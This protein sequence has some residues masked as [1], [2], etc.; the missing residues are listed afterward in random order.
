MINTG[1]METDML[2]AGMLPRVYFAIIAFVIGTVFGSFINCM[3]WRIVHKESVIHGR[4][5][6]AVC[7]HELSAAD[8]VPVFS[9]IFLKG[10]CRYCGEKISPRYMAAELVAGTA[11]LA[12]FLKWGLGIDT[13]RWMAMSAVLLGLSLVD[14]D[15]Y[16]IPD[17]FILAA[18]A[19]WI[20]TMPFSHEWDVHEGAAVYFPAEPGFIAGISSGILRNIVRAVAHGGIGA[21]VISGGMLIVSLIFDR[22]TGKESLGGGDIKLFFSAGLYLGTMNGLLCVIVSCVLGLII[23]AV[24]RKKRIPFGPEISASIFLCA[25]FGQNAVNWYMNLIM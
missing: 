8:L 7:G 10:K 21:V 22:V 20:V 13:A 19:V 24:R 1:S 5:H 2:L 11:F 23:A 3:A 17:R 25:M 16:E 12:C 6:C 15:I 14:L 18:M 9:Y 4:S